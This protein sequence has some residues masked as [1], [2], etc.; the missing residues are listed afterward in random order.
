M[1]AYGSP[2]L[3]VHLINDLRPD[4]PNIISVD[5]L[6]PNIGPVDLRK[7]YIIL[8]VLARDEQGNIYNIEVQ[9]RRYGAWNPRGLFYLARILGQQLASGEDYSKLRAA[10]GIHLLAF[11]LFTANNKQ[12]AQA[13]WRF[14]MRDAT[15]PEVS[16]G[17]LLQMNLIELNKADRLGLPAGGLRAWVTFFKHWR[18][19]RIM[20][21][22]THEPTRHALDRLRRISA[23]DEAYYQAL[24][25]E[26]ALRDE[27][28]LLHEARQEGRL[29]GRQE[30]RQEGMKEGWEGGMKNGQRLAATNLI[31]SGMFSDNAQ[32]AQITGLSP[33]EV[34]ALRAGLLH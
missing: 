5:V 32:I 12:L 33:E 18:D 6:N 17:N 3:L 30:G 24:A 21:E 22:M 9:V 29:E 23:D 25:R 4:L 7:K 8:D 1:N 28:S 11:D 14:E 34:Q 16:F 10:V 31:Q 19:E 15:R 2:E 20:A 27:V 13:V 26:R